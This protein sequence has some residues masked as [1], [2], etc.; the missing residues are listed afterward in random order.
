MIVIIKSFY[1]LDFQER[2]RISNREFRVARRP[3]LS[4][5]V[6]LGILL[7]EPEMEKVVEGDFAEIFVPLLFVL[8]SYAG[9]STCEPRPRLK[10]SQVRIKISFRFK[11]AQKG[12]K[13]SQIP[14]GLVVVKFIRFSF[15]CM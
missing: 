9:V 4:S 14:I 7:N 15:M 6:A 10:P 2:D 1:K 8:A 12:F 13:L 3:Y 11:L 5:V